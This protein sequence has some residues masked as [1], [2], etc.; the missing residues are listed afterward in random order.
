[1]MEKEQEE[2]DMNEGNEGQAPTSSTERPVRTVS[3]RMRRRDMNMSKSEDMKPTNEDSPAPTGLPAD[4]QPEA[5]DM[6]K[7][8]PKDVLSADKNASQT[9]DSGPATPGKPPRGKPRRREE[10]IAQAV[11]SS[12]DEFGGEMAMAMGS[13]PLKVHEPL[14][15]DPIKAFQTR[16]RRIDRLALNAVPE[17]HIVGQI[18]SSLNVVTN[19]TEGVFCRWKVDY[20]KAWAWLGGEVQGQTQVSYCKSSS[21]ECITFNHPMDLHF[22]EAGLQ[23]WGAPRLAVQVYR[24]DFYGRRI[25]AGY[26]FVH[27]PL[28]PGLHNIEVS[29]WRPSGNPEQ[30]LESFILGQTP[31]LTSHEPVYESAWRDRC[32]LVTVSAGKV[33]VEVFVITR[34]TKKQNIDN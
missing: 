10:D 23:G 34:N 21:S 27:F 12:L 5:D 25:L 18:V 20:G 14:R 7:S 19:V 31:A 30:E 29:L 11:V 2:V 28:T 32:R 15:T 16:Q 13:V 24:M 9:E 26:G 33:F 17:V 8:E 4:E 22:A 6:N 1:M 3:R